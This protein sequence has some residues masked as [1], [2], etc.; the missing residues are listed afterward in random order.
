MAEIFLNEYDNFE[1]ALKKIQGKDR[2]RGHLF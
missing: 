2:T 1:V